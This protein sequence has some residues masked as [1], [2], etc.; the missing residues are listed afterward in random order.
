M[1]ERT[2]KPW[3]GELFIPGGRIVPGDD[4]I[5][6]CQKNAHR[7]L[8]FTPDSA[9]ITF[10]GWKSLLNPEREH[11]GGSYFTLLTLFEVR[12]TD[13]QAEDIVLDRTA[14]M[15]VWVKP[16]E[17]AVPAAVRE[18]FAQAFGV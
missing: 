10:K 7:E 18:I 16:N 9:N 8:G 6:A 12:V 2:E 3:K 5:V 13:E 17:T 4:P 15:L 11:G 1:T 14:K